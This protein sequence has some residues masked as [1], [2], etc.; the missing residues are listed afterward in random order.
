MVGSLPFNE[1]KGCP[2]G[3]HKRISYT[4]KLGHR[5]PP[6]CVKSQTVYAENRKHFT[7][8]MTARQQ[9]RLKSVGKSATRK[10]DC[11]EGMIERRGY[12]RKFAADVIQKG[13][14]VHRKD[15]KTY[16]IRPKKE[17]VFVRSACIKDRGRHGKIAPGQGFGALRRGE[18]KKYG[19]SYRESTDNRHTALKK[20]IDEFGALGVFRKLDVIA[21]LSKRTVPEAAN[22]FKDDREWVQDKYKLKAP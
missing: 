14:S 15:G 22:I 19:Y 4:S 3:F 12:V 6:R 5:V 7:Q 8:R 17:S 21:K 11:G 10:L 1:N 16:R 2:D 20:A 9:N 18:L 13:Y